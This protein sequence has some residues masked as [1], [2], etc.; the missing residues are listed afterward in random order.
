MLDMTRVLT[1]KKYI[2]VIS[3]RTLANSIVTHDEGC[4]KVFVDKKIDI[5]EDS[6]DILLH[7]S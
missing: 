7:L 2:K 6:V 5:T 3:K 1:I 4:D